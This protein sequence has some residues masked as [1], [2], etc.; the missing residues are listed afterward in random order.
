MER[1]DELK[2]LIARHSTGQFT[3]TLIPGLALVR[4]DAV[5]TSALHVV[6][7]PM[8][9]VAAQGSKRVIVGRSIVEY[10]AADYLVVSV[11][12]P[13]VASVTSATPER[14]YL[15]TSL[16]LDPQALAALLLELPARQPAGRPSRG[17]AATR[18]PPELL[19][20]FVRLLR[21]LDRPA[22]IDV[23]APLIVREIGYRL[24]TGPHAV[25]V[26]Q[27]AL[28]KSRTAQVTRAIGWIRQNY[29]KPLR[30]GALARLAGMSP[31]SLHRHFKAVTAIS[32]LQYRQQIRLLEARRLL[33]SQLEDAAA[34]AFTVGYG[35]PSQ[36]SRE[37]RR[38]FGAPPRQDVE[39]IRTGGRGLSAA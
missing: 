22:D 31:A 37:Y 36:F 15:A 30:V 34:V 38:L 3:R 12:L 9:C 18:T 10:G 39:R 11:D 8:V 19:D 28:R 35:S 20:A 33:V 14:P 17:I 7:S 23:L 27:I 32:P 2:R 21:L 13:A 5:T 29:T 24:L 26:R 4:S 1:L 25:M 6:G 16:M